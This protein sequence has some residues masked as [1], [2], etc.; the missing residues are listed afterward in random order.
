MGVAIGTASEAANEWILAVTAGV[1]LYIALVDLVSESCD[2][3]QSDWS[4][5]TLFPG[6]VSGKAKGFRL[7]FR[8]VYYVFRML[9]LW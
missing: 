7:G 4:E 6:L 3:C 1:F 2:Q 5:S 9:G 8:A